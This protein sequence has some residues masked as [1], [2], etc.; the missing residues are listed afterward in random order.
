MFQ[1]FI[2]HISLRVHQCAEMFK[3]HNSA[4]DVDYNNPHNEPKQ[5]IGHKEHESPTPY[6]YNPRKQ[7]T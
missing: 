5:E 1:D 7:I 2:C 4:Y 6:Q 3:Q